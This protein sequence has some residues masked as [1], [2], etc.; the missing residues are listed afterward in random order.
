[1]KNSNQGKELNNS[2]AANVKQPAAK[3]KSGKKNVPDYGNGDFTPLSETKSSNK[4]Q[5]PAVENL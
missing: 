1:M 2:R 4:G 3:N 5:G